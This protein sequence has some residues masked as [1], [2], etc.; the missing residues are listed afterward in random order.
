MKT[1]SSAM[2]A[3]LQQSVTT[4]ATCWR[5]TRT[6]GLVLGFTDHDQ[7]LDVGGLMY[8][9]ATGF[10]PSATSLSSAL[11]SNHMDVTGLLDSARITDVDIMAGRYDGADIAVF[12]VNYQDIGQGSIPL[13]RGQIGRITLHEGQF[14][15]EIRGLSHLL[16]HTVGS[17][18]SRTCRAELG[19]GRCRVEMGS[20]TVTGNVTRVLSETLLEDVARTEA[21][22]LYSQGLLTMTSGENAG[23]QREV[24]SYTPQTLRLHHPFPYAI[25]I[26]TT[27]T[28]T[29]GC[30]KILATC[31]GRFANAV[32]FRGEPHVPGTDKLLETATTRSG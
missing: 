30:D 19:D 27:Y 22:G 1:L 26:G 15:A 6:D 13:H 14:V 31:A 8:D 32:N 23:I 4:L 11:D 3:H 5:I 9:A 25:T 20:R 18:Y 12:R 7:P 28:L 17:L 10:L 21:A 29:Q 2:Q 16:Q 24:K